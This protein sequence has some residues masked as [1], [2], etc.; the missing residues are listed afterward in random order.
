M[1]H[2]IY[3]GLLASESLLLKVKAL[4]HLQKTLLRERK[5]YQNVLHKRCGDGLTAQQFDGL[6]DLLEKGKF[7]VRTVG[8][9]GAVTVSL[10]ESDTQE[11][12]A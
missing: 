1:T 4:N 3:V 10:I 9:R 11:S 6:V 5:G 7:C 8:E 2:N 12:V